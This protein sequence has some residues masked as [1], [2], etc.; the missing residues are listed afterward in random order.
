MEKILA[1]YLTFFVDMVY[2][3]QEDWDMLLSSIRNGVI[4]DIDHIDDVR[5]SLQVGV[6]ETFEPVATAD[7][8]RLICVLIHSERTSLR[9]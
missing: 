9:A 2:Y 8:N 3:I 6:Y 4:P 5:D 7:G 1:G